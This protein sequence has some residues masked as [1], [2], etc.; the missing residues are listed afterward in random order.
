[1]KSCVD[2]GK[3]GVLQPTE[4]IFLGETQCL[5]TDL[6]KKETENV[7]QKFGMV[8]SFVDLKRKDF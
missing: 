5:V 4:A 3:K 2:E 8:R 6:E 7:A 1:M